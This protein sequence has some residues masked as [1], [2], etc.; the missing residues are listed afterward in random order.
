MALVSPKEQRFPWQC[1]C[2]D[3]FKVPSICLFLSCL[4]FSVHHP[5]PAHPHSFSSSLLTFS[6]PCL[7][8]WSLACPPVP[9]APPHSLPRCC[10]AP[11]SA[12]KFPEA[13]LAAGLTPETP[14]EIL[15]LEFKETRC[16][17][18]R[19]GDDW[20]LMLRNTI[21]GLSW[22]QRGHS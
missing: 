17:P 10:L 12:A 18:M 21:E 1:H 19:K 22:P 7:A 14:A 9:P 6:F 15:A 2:R 20:T 16:T 3:K 11:A 4:F 5:I 13:V 8:L